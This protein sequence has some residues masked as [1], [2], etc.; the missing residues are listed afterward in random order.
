MDNRR[1]HVATAPAATL[2]RDRDGDVPAINVAC[3]DGQREPRAMV[4]ILR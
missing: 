2:R 3:H 4:G 1:R